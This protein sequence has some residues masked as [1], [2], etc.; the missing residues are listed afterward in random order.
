MDHLS[1][2][3]AIS[4]DSIS[5]L[6]FSLILDKTRLI[7]WFIQGPV[8]FFNVLTGKIPKALLHLEG[9]GNKIDL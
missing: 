5:I 3:K 9:N 2:V 6:L 4:S 8:F 1:C 7:K